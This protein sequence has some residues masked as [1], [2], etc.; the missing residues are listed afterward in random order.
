MKPIFVLGIAG[1]SGSGKTTIVEK[2]LAGPLGSHIV[3]LSHDAY[4]HPADHYGAAE[5]PAPNYDHPDSLDNALYVSHVKQLLAG[6]PIAQPVYD[7]ARHDRLARTLSVAPS[8]VLLL[9]GILILAIP[10]IRELIDLAV[11]VETPAD[12]RILRRTL[13][14]IDAR[15]RTPQSIASQYIETVRPM[16]EQFVEPSRYHAHVWIPWVNENPVAL[17]L[18]EKRLALAIEAR[19]SAV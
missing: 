9:E 1:G 12:L 7:F 2:L 15:G 17:D 16:N 18:L 4:Y 8:A 19:Q 6:E 3:V 5:S 11:Y 13:R 10:Q 14:D